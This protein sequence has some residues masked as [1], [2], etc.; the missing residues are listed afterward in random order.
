[1]SVRRICF[2]IVALM[3]IRGSAAEVEPFRIV[4][5]VP[6]YPD[7]AYTD[8]YMRK[9]CRLNL[10]LPTNTNGFAT[11]VWFH[12]GGLIHGF[13]GGFFRTPQDDVASVSAGYRL[14]TNAT[15]TEC[16]SDAAAVVAWTLKHIREYGGDPKKVFVS[17]SSGG[18]YLSLMMGMDPKWLKPH[19]WKPTDLAGILPETGQVSTHFTIRKENGDTTST[20]VTK[21]DEWSPLFHAARDLPPILLQTGEPEIDI[22]C[23]A[24]E[25]RLLYASL[26]ELWHPDLEWHAYPGR[27][28]GTMAKDA[29]PFESDFIHRRI[30]QI[31]RA[32]FS[33]GSNPVRTCLERGVAEGLRTDIVSI[34]SDAAYAHRDTC[35][36]DS[37]NRADLV[38][39]GAWLVPL[40][41]KVANA[42]LTDEGRRLPESGAKLPAPDPRH[43]WISDACEAEM[44]SRVLDE[45]GMSQTRVRTDKDG[46]RFW[47][48]TAEDAIRLAELIAHR[49]TWRGRTFFSADAA[50]REFPLPFSFADRIF[51]EAD[52]SSAV[53]FL[54]KDLSDRA[55]F[56]RMSAAWQRVR[57]GRE[58]PP[59]PASDAATGPQN[60][61]RAAMEA[62]VGRGDIAGIV[63]IVTD[64][65]YAEQVD[66]AGW[67]DVENRVPM[68]PD[69]MFAL[70][71]ST[72]S[73]AGTAVMILVDEGKLSLDDPVSKYLPE[74]SDVRVE[75]V[76]ADGLVTLVPP[77]RPI[78]VRDLM[79]HTTGSGL[80]VPVVKRNFPLRVL[81]HW[82]AQTPLKAEPGEMFSYNNAGIDTGGAVVEVVSG[83]PFD[84]FCEKR[85][86]RP[87]GMVDTT[88]VP[89]ADQIRRMARPYNADGRPIELQFGG[90]GPRPK[91]ADQCNLPA[92][93]KVHPCPSGGLYSTPRDFARY[94]QMLAHHGEWK[95]VRIISRKTFDEVF[96]VRQ[97]DLKLPDADYT[98]G[99]WLRGE[100]F[101]HSGA[102][103]T[104]QRVNLRTG[105]SRLFFVQVVPPGG[106]GLDR[107]K[108]DWSAA[109]DAVQCAQGATPCIYQAPKRKPSEPA[110]GG[111]GV[112]SP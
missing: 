34:V 40:L 20:Y 101:G 42:C 95:G 67:A 84:Q 17:G 90:K 28:H 62:A 82:M 37:G 3:A 4:R 87:L 106:I 77:R 16:L 50:A 23:R 55:A 43:P 31:D 85:I 93:E 14:L 102:L 60:G 107:A 6:Y 35:V 24:E 8:D 33:S 26:K 29:K 36:Q 74:F 68:S 44:F 19:G 22:P 63:S 54:R 15:P 69:T 58:V 32:L 72:K 49:G 108:D 61:I 21:A 47:T 1:M 12:G 66:C 96:A 41:K 97:T 92:L 5:D 30:R 71:S 39:D 65:D 70:F 89:N 53:L 88:F 112:V 2:A 104:D 111:T 27:R 56:A 46:A 73:V 11:V 10:R 110:A 13:R 18:G 38:G 76:N 86:F 94:S 75:K 81:A 45:L 103:K 105:H 98:V 64:P 57:F 59:D 100:W 91:Y 9:F 80:D 7:R 83:L 25:N 52:G 109:V 79:A 51:A 78:T 48:T 99:N